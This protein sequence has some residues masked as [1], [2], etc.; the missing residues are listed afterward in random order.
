MQKEQIETIGD[1]PDKMARQY[2]SQSRTH[3]HFA[4]FTAV[5]TKTLHLS[6]Q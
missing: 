2:I 4:P 6:R 5:K 3:S 1:W